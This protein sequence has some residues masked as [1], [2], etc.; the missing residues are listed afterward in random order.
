[1]QE[2]IIN[3]RTE[4]QANNVKKT[5]VLEECNQ[6]AASHD[7]EIDRNVEEEDRSKSI[8]E[9]EIEDDVGSDDEA[10][11]SKNQ[12]YIFPTPEEVEKCAEPCV[13][14]RFQSLTEAQRYLNVHGLLNGY[15]IRKGTNYLK[16]TYHLEC[17]RS[18]KARVMEN[19]QRIRRRNYIVKTDCKMKVIVKLINEQ[20]VFTKVDTVHNHNVVSS[21]SLT[22]FFLNHKR[23]TDDEK[24]FSKILQD[25]RIKPMKIMAIF[26]ELKGSFKNV[27]FN[28]R[29][30]DNLKQKER[31][32]TRNSD[33]EATV[34]YLKKVQI[35]SPG[36]YYTMRVD[37]E[38]RVKS[39]FWTDARGKMDY[40]L[41]GDFISFDTTF[42]TN[43]YNMPFAPIVGINGHAK[44]VIF[45]CALLEDQTA[46]TFEWVFKTFVETM[47]GKKPKI[48]M[49]DQDAAMKKAIADFMP[50]VIHRL[51]I[52]HIMKN[53][54]EKCG[55]FMSQKHREGMEKKLNE[56]VYDSLSV[57]EFESGWQQMLKDYDAEK[58]EHLQTMYRLRKMW[59]PVYFKEV[60]RPFIHSTSRS[61]STNSYFKDY[62]IPKYTVENFMM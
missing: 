40:E 14:M 49:T 41:Y 8:E 42:S 58:N 39:I 35:E 6:D 31:I 24:A 38:N 62:V 2:L 57:L 23:M 36:F 11:I 7:L 48:I 21:P 37:E 9:V 17:N 20:W 27:F 59:I 13:G 12:D 22:K 46:E 25:A 18:G 10:T 29:N 32:K 3:Q 19:P 53:I 50:D 55:S 1:M 43:K 16:K 51:C 61:E 60:L 54:L 34:N 5:I 56:L 26:R 45:G 28:A 44:N 52:W 33:I 47:N 4:M 15:A 30:L